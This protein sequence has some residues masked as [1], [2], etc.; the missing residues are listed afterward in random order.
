MKD[1]MPPVMAR[2]KGCTP[3]VKEEI[4]SKTKKNA[5]VNEI[6]GGFFAV[7]GKKIL[8]LHK[9]LLIEI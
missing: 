9:L 4:Y 1:R 3:P 2:N 5:V 6:Y 8:S 7:F